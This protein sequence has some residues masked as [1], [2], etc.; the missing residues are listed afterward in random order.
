M[1]TTIKY[2]ET[3]FRVQTKPKVVVIRIQGSGQL[4]SNNYFQNLGSFGLGMMDGTLDNLYVRVSGAEIL[5]NTF[6]NCNNTFE[7]G[8]NHS[9]HPN[10]TPPINCLIEGNVIYFDKSVKNKL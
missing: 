10:G 9:K 3:F 2:L 6:A 8:I 7:I 5:F 1:G 4:I